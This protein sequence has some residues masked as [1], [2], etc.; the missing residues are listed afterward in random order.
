MAQEFPNANVIGVDLSPVENETPPQNCRFFNVDLTSPP[1]PFE[2]NS[3]DV[4]QMRTVPSIPDRSLIIS[5]VYRVLRPNGLILFVEPSRT[6]S[7]TLPGRIQSAAFAEVDSLVC[8]SPH[9]VGSDDWDLG[10]KTHAM[11]FNSKN[12]DGKSLFYAVEEKT[13]YLPVGMW[14]EDPQQAQ[15]GALG[16]ENHIDLL[17]GFG[18][19]FIKHG[20]ISE[21]GFK[22]LLNRLIAE[23]N[24]DSLR[25]E[26]PWV[27]VWGQKRL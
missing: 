5:D 16:A 7:G 18:P 1:L 21:D 10:K 6:V 3:F 17:E 13:I 9:C 22:A 24:D 8:L 20:L 4:V 12:E 26:E 15:L 11:I 2:D 14:P 23:T 25:L 27:F 19:M